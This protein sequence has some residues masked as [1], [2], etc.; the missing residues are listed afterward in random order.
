M[1]ADSE[2]N[3][4]I[5]ALQQEPFAIA[6]FLPH[7]AGPHFGGMTKILILSDIKETVT[8]LVEKR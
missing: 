8:P 2:K 7:R 3:K 4:N 5:I 6:L 1:R